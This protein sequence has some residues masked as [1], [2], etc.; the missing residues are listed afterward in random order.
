MRS[1][2]TVTAIGTMLLAGLS[3]C[4]FHSLRSSEP[5]STA[6]ISGPPPPRY[7]N[8]EYQ[9]AV[10]YPKDGVSREQGE[11]G[12]FDQGGWRTG[13][14]EDVPGELLLVLRLEDSNR[15]RAGEL[16]LGVSDDAEALATCTE[17]AAWVRPDGVGEARLDGVAF[18]TFQGGDAAMHHY[19][20]VHAYRARHQ[21]RCYAIDLVVQGS[22]GQLYDPPRQAPFSESRAFSDLDALLGGVEFTD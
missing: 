5:H 8:A 1:V 19:R 4:D 15:I 21:G 10:S 14:G 13:A 11:R 18:T 12:Y 17:P 9:I 6:V 16:R 2:I 20:K 22:N 7:Q 3:G